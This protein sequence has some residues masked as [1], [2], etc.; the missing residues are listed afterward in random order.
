FTAA[1]SFSAGRHVLPT[2]SR[3]DMPPGAALW[4]GR[5]ANLARATWR[6]KEEA[7]NIDRLCQLTMKNT[8][9]NRSAYDGRASRSFRRT[10][11][12]SPAPPREAGR[13]QRRL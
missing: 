7:V 13:R 10:P 1:Q 8:D 9:V 11:E 6:K 4:G 5:E 3:E 2:R 12:H